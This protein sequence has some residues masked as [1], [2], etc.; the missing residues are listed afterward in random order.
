VP[1]DRPDDVAAEQ[2]RLLAQAEAMSGLPQVP[3]STRQDHADEARTLL[4]DL[5]AKR[6]EVRK[7]RREAFRTRSLRQWAALV[8]RDQA[9]SAFSGHQLWERNP[10]VRTGSQLTFGERSADAMR[11]SFGSW[12][13]VGA[14]A[15]FLAAWMV[16]NTVLLGQHGWDHYPYIL[17]NLALSMLAAVQGALI[18]IAAKRADRVSAEQALAHYA[19]TAKLDTLQTQNN[20]M[21][22]RIETATGLL[23]EI[24]QHV[25]ALSSLAGTFPPD[26]PGQARTIAGENS[27]AQDES[28][29]L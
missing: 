25:S 13:F 14:F 10:H 21:T 19:E 4:T 3:A 16:I 5:A 18:L 24:H 29:Q 7:L 20:E 1:G 11:N 6:A 15:L 17:L 28:G 23:A 9:G 26:I 27:P 2:H 22:S 12:R 8:I